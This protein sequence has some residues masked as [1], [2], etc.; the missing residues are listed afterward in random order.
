MLVALFLF[1]AVGPARA[2]NGAESSGTWAAPVVF[3]SGLHSLAVAWTDAAAGEPPV[4]GYDLQYRTTG[5]TEWTD[6]P[7][8][9][10]A[11][12]AGIGNL[13]KDTN[14]EVR[15]RAN[16]GGTDGA[17]SAPREG[18]TALWTAAL[19]VGAWNHSATG[20]WGY[21][22]RRAMFGHLNPTKFSYRDLEYDIFILSWYRRPTD[23]AFDFYTVHNQIPAD[24]VVRV[25]SDRFFATD[26][27]RATFDNY[28]VHG[29]AEKIYWSHVD[30]S[31][32]LGAQYDIAISRALDRSGL[33]I[34][35]LDAAGQRTDRQPGYGRRFVD[36]RRS[37]T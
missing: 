4:T 24:W 37:R 35:P 32:V 16:R 7:Q 23:P 25:G 2:Q 13:L 1:P 31:L 33:R 18:A 22:R 11:T 21:Q 9:L 26:G 20:Y 15:V 8:D 17:W 3:E 14:Y 34:E 36:G 10:T 27:A 30:F 5:S 19:T 29:R 6:G 28:P 12:H